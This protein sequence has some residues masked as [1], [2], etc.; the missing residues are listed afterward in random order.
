MCRVLR[1]Y[2]PRTT[3]H[4]LQFQILELA[5]YVRGKTLASANLNPSSDGGVFL[6]SFFAS[7]LERVYTQFHTVVDVARLFQTH[8]VNLTTFPVV[9]DSQEAVQLDAS[10]E[11]GA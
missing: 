5:G 1:P 3:A 9:D 7:T 8:D 4:G 2:V 11:T 10:A 6:P